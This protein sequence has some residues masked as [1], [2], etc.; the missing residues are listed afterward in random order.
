MFFKT[1]SLQ[2]SALIIALA[3]VSFGTDLVATQTQSKDLT[4][5]RFGA[6]AQ[7]LLQ[8]TST[9]TMNTMQPIPFR[10]VNFRRNTK[11]KHKNS[12]VK[13]KIPGLYE[14]TA[15]FSI[16]NPVTDQNYA[17]NVLIN[18]KKYLNFQVTELASTQM[19]FTALGSLYLK[20]GDEV[21][22]ALTQA[23]AGTVIGGDRFL[24]MLLVRESKN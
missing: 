18:G 16:M 24:T 6:A 22:I 23:P 3:A 13:V 19:Q 21:S 15:Q 11:L 2:K 7:A 1:M 5:E 20:R 10:T 4:R 9:L 12:V 14:I 17:T 8:D